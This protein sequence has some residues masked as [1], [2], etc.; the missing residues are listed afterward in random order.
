M[1]ISQ[2]EFGKYLFAHQELEALTRQYQL[3]RREAIASIS[4]TIT[5]FDY[6]LR[7]LRK[8]SINVENYA[9][10]LEEIYSEF[11]S[12]A[13]EF[14]ERTKLLEEAA[15]L[16]Y[17]DERTQYIA[18]KEQ[19]DTQLY[20]E[21]LEALKECLEYVLEGFA[22]IGETEAMSVE[23]WDAA[24]DSMDNETLFADYYD[25]DDSFDNEILKRRAI[26]NGHGYLAEEESKIEVF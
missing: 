7:E 14:E 10:Y 17:E 12:K 11:K 22:K 8:S 13:A 9:I 15:S 24:V 26:S 2:Y 6:D 20:P 1:A 3:E 19:S 25:S 21:V 23:E 4:P 18:W 5:A 16:L